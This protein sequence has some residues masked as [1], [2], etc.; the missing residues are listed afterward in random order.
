MKVFCKQTTSYG[1][2][3]NE[4]NTVFSNNFDYS[5]G[6][7]GLKI[8]EEYIVMGVAMYKN[9][10]C[11]YYLIDTNGKPDWFPYLLF[12][13]IDD[14]IPQNWYIKVS[15]STGDTGLYSLIGFDELCNE[16]DYYDRLLERE[17]DAMNVYFTRKKEMEGSS[18]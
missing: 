11:L 7:Y 2:D 10:Q 4:V 17:E 14:T 5:F 12:T 3:L 8:D 16:T 18:A 6:G 1:F 13:I 15:G 9:S